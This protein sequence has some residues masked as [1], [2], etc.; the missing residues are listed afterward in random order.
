[1]AGLTK[2]QSG[3]IGDNF[4]FDGSGTL[5]LDSTNDRVG[6]GHTT[7]SHKLQILH[8][9]TAALKVGGNGSHVDGYH[10][11]LGQLGT[12]T[13]AGIKYTGSGGS[14][15]FHN[16]SGEV[17]RFRP[18]GEF[19]INQTAKHGTNARSSWYSWLHIKGN[20][21]ADTSDGRITLTS[22]AT[23]SGTAA[24]GS[25]YFADL[26]GGDRAA[27]RAHQEGAGNSSDNFPG[28]LSFWTNSG[29]S[30]PTEK[31]RI[32]S[33]GRVCMGTTTAT[34]SRNLTLTGLTNDAGIQINGTT[35][36]G[37]CYITNTPGSSAATYIGNTN[38]RNLNFVVGGNVSSKMVIDSAGHVGIGDSDPTCNLHVTG[39]NNYANNTSSLSEV[40]TKSPVRIQGSNNSST[41][42]YIGSE[43]NDSDIYLQV[44]N[45]NA[46]ATDVLQL[47][48]YGGTV[49]IGTREP[50]ALL[51]VKF[52]SSSNVGFV[53][54][55]TSQGTM[56]RFLN[57]STIVGS[58]T[59]TSSATAYN[60]SSDYRLKDNV[61]TLDGAIN[62]VKQLAPKR[63]NF[64]ID[65]DKTVDG[66]LAHEAQTVV[67]EAVTGTKDETDADN[68]PV[69][70]GIDQAK[71][72]PLLTAALQE[73][74][75]RIETLEAEVTVLKS[76]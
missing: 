34:A 71:L 61:V 39:S 30:N 12:N 42:L 44:A 75:K 43:N 13:S 47:Q 38:S 55:N 67:P 29:T 62:R 28:R 23:L 26:N 17:A 72:V 19:L 9:N 15:M 16:S 35:S 53:L 59:N 40:A 5:K 11:E 74:I 64:K 68:Q 51:E 45:E 52:D 36:G 33:V 20:T 22:G 50:G 65:A 54:K 56:A 2:I 63:F 41:S 48:P 18:D 4:D 24:I 10:L 60:T 69:Y 76:N 3:G 14:M 66:F 58:I 1:M 27:I 32:D 70:Q 37:N 21:F 49:G 6:I 57:N 7:P 73:A 25:I 46:S 8:D 31:M